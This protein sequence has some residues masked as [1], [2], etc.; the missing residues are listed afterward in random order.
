[1]VKNS[2]KTLG[3]VCCTLILIVS[4]ANVGVGYAQ[5]KPLE[6]SICF[7]TSDPQK[8]ANDNP[9]DVV[10]KYIEAKFNIK[11]KEVIQPTSGMS[12]KERLNLF[13]AANNLPDVIVSGQDFCDYAASTGKFA[14]LS[15]YIPQMKNLNRYFPQN[16]W[17]R[18]MSDGK[19]YQIPQVQITPNDPKFKD[20]PFNLSYFHALWMRED[21]LAKLGY[22]FAPLNDISKQ[23]M[24]KGKKAPLAAYQITPAIDT[25]EKFYDLLKKIK[26]LD[27]KVGDKEM[28]PF[29]STWWSSFHIG[30]M[31]DYGHWRKDASGDVDGFLGAPG[32]HDWLKMLWSMYQGKLIDQDYVL[33]KDDQLQQKIAS[34]LVAAGMYIPDFNGAVNGLAA[35]NPNYKIRFIPLPKQDQNLG[36]YDIIQPGF[37]RWMVRKDFK[38]I[39]RLVQYFDW[40]YSDEG[41]DI[42]TWGPKSAGLWEL[43]NGKKVFKNAELADALLKGTK[44]GKKGPEYYGLYAPMANV[45]QYSNFTAKAASCAPTMCQ[46]NPFDSRKSYPIKLDKYLANRQVAIGGYDMKGIASYGD[47]SATVAGVATYFWGKFQNDRIGMILVS[48]SEEEFE[49]NFK[50]QVAL[51]KKETNYNAAKA[52][53]EKWYKAN[54]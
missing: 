29:S 6:Y 39:K 3:L 54:Q 12:A 21:I 19:K 8:Y 9:N 10:T 28:I 40:F 31:F 50:E 36:F 47:G 25:P 52:N 18:Y 4:L 43:E 1:M 26:A 13:I 44:T 35:I 16:M 46:F 7:G 15:E 27:L 41:F 2:K 37:W 11:V 20:D 17:P 49:K 34:G 45:S 22:K 42:C 23:Y 14:D 24:D 32:A 48:K 33:Q 53:M 5:N 38:D 30:S 51:F